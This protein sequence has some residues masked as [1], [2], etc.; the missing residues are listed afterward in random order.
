MA[1]QPA[2]ILHLV[3]DALVNENGEIIPKEIA[4]LLEEI[5]AL[6]VDKKMLRRDITVKNRKIAELERDVIEERLNYPRRGEIERVGVYWHR[7]CRPEDWARPV[8]KV[9]PLAPVRFDAVRGILEIERLIIDVDPE[10]GKTKKR[11][12]PFYT[13]EDFKTAI[14]GAAFDPFR[15]QRKNGSW[16]THNDLE[17]ICRSAK[18]FDEFI[19]KAPVRAPVVAPEPE[20]RDNP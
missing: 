19:A 3:G 17:L 12:E 18:H 13:A 10:T 16:Q 1:A 4:K 8:R 5:A 9:Q 11:R 14:D 2:P 15:T 6:K 20:T 7:K